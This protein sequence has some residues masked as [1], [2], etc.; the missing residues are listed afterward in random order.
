MT[1][2]KTKVPRARRT[3]PARRRELILE[4]ACRQ[5]MQSDRPGISFV[6]IAR[7]LGVARSL[8][9]H[10]FPN[11]EALMTALAEK[12]IWGFV[13]EAEIPDEGTPE[14]KLTVLFTKLSDYL[15]E[16]P[17]YLTELIHT[18]Q[19]RAVLDAASEGKVPL[20]IR[21]AKSCFDRSFGTEDDEVFYAL[22]MFVRFLLI[23]NCRLP[24]EERLKWVRVAVKTALAAAEA[25]KEFDLTEAK[26]E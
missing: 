9:Y 1:Q 7:K 20:F 22:P 12:Y 5:C 2:K 4:E 17:D 18:R 16:V 14:E 6:E 11:Q 19:G 13:T 15:A 3:A 24:R 23:R 8:V 10:Y 21:L 26:H 25:T